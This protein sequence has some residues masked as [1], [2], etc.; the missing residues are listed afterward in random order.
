MVLSPH[1]ILSRL[2][3]HQ[4]D[5]IQESLAD[6]GRQRQILEHQCDEL[7]KYRK[8]LMA[9]RD[10]ALQGSTTASMLM[11]IGDAMQEQHV[12]LA[13]I[14]KDLA[15]LKVSEKELVQ[16]LVKANQKCEVHDKMQSHEVKSAERVQERRVQQQMDDMFAA[17]YTREAK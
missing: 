15:A 17:R 5:G 7:I 9:E 3:E 1:Q 12:R 16:S 2:A 4:R 11:M 10:Q 8:Q 14:D 13:C 6:L